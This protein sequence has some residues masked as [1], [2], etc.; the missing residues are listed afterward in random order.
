MT[1]FKYIPKYVHFSIR[2]I[3]HGSVVMENDRSTDYRTFFIRPS[4]TA[5]TRTSAE[6]S[7]TTRLFDR[8]IISVVTNAMNRRNRNACKQSKILNEKKRYGVGGTVR[9]VRVNEK[10]EKQR[11][12]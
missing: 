9:R 3:Y 10:T 6:T 12:G 1:R 2:Y 8:T 4:D 5:S 7:R 11:S